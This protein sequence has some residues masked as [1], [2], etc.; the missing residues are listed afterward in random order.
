MRRILRPIPRAPGV[1]NRQVAV[2]LGGRF[3]DEL[4]SEVPGVLLPTLQRL[5]G[6]SYVQ[7]SAL[8]LALDYVAA[9][10]EPVSG[11]LLDVWDRRWI[12]AWGAVLTGLAIVV[13]GVAPTFLLLLLGFALYGLGTGPLAHTGDVVLV[14]MH[15]D[16]PDRI[17]ARSVLLDSVGA[18]LGPLLVSLFFWLNL[19]WRWLLVGLGATGILFAVVVWRTRLP[20]PRGAQ[21]AREEGLLRTVRGNISAVWA[22]GPART[23]LLFLLVYGL[24]ETPRRFKTLFLADH[25]GMSQALI[26]VYVA[27]EL[28]SGMAGLLFLDRWRQTASVRRIL[29]VAAGAVAVLYPLWLLT[30]GIWPRFALALPLEFLFAVFWPIGR[31]QALASA[32]GRAGVV[33]A[34]QGLYG[35][36]PFALLFGLLA[37]RVTLPAAMLGVH[38]VM[39]PLMG[40]LIWRLDGR[41]VASVPAS[42]DKA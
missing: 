16:A 17:F 7:V 4:L 35:L 5:F 12:M 29:S 42:D 20:A 24:L 28:G 40:W 27:V 34:V 13:I 22:H 11:L 6:L 31:A 2:G 25:A 18:L 15:P 30:P 23:W 3:F 1:T 33:T 9:A 38:G 19:P 10:V 41:A 21:Q 8:G 32:P 36:V 26:G 39:I 37:D 14:E